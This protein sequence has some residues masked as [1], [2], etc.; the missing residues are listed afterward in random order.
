MI[1][2]VKMVMDSSGADSD[3]HNDRNPSNIWSVILTD[4]GIF[5]Y[6]GCRL[7]PRTLANFSGANPQ[8]DFTFGLA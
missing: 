6:T 4:I 7:K 3:L 2:T 5:A 8:A 1:L